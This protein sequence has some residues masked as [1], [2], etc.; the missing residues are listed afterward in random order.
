[1]SSRS[2]TREFGHFLVKF[3]VDDSYYVCPRIKVLTD[4]RVRIGETYNVVWGKSD[5]DSD[6]AEILDSGDWL[7]LRKKMFE[8][9]QD[10]SSPTSPL[11]AKRKMPASKSNGPSKKQK[12]EAN[13][14]CIQEGTTV[15]DPYQFLP[16]S[17][18]LPFHLTATSPVQPPPL[19]QTKETQTPSDLPAFLLNNTLCDILKQVNVISTRQVQ[20][21]N[22]LVKQQ[23]SID[24][25]TA[26]VL[27]Q[28]TTSSANL[29]PPHIISTPII[30][31]QE[32]PCTSTT[33]RQLQFQCNFISDSG[34]MFTSSTYG[35]SSS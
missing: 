30:R 26:A 21:D 2:V 14:L 6:F 16:E 1:M 29:S 24:N 35:S 8:K 12:A 7:D 33:S 5:D 9:E 28:T 32:L 13:L 10:S 17:P 25:L 18:V 34:N 27:R 22:M 4:G 31:R 19:T 15:S 20:I 11:Q 3:E 23:Q